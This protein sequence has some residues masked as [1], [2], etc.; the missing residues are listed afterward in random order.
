MRI[1]W[2]MR[3]C[4]YRIRHRETCRTYYGMTNDP[5]ARWAMHLREGSTCRYL[6]AALQAHGREAFDWDVL[7]WYESRLAAA[8]AERKLIQEAREPLYNLN[9]YT[10]PGEHN[11]AWC[12]RA[13]RRVET[14]WPDHLPDFDDGGDFHPGG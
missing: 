5:T 8:R 7:E 14:D 2:Y 11:F 10:K 12:A 9:G 4:T 6:A 3:H 1:M 13:P